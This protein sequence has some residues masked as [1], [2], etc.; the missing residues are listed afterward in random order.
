MIAIINKEKCTG[1]GKC[2]DSCPADMISIIDGK[3]TVNEGCLACGAC[4]GSCPRD[5]ISF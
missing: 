1:C 2:I 3:A 5:A 4:I